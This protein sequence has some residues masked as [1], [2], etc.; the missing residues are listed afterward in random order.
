MRLAGSCHCRAVV[1]RLEVPAPV[2]FQRC[3]CT[4]CRKTAGSGGFAINIGGLAE[5]LEI[6]GDGAAHLGT[7]RARLA[8]GTESAAERRFCTRCGCHLWLWHP[9]W[10][11]LIHPHAGAI[12]TE[13]PEPPERVHMMLGSR[14]GWAA[15]EPGPGDRCFDAYPEESLADWHA[16]HDL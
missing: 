11:A 14:A 1:F 5:T 10:P 13:L 9:R 8:D 2:P 16:R 7:Y 3:Y 4:I 15:P 6:E 12:D